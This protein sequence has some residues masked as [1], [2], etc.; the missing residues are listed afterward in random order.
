M[1]QQQQNNGEKCQQATF[2]K[3]QFK[4]TEDQQG[5]RELEQTLGQL[6]LA[7]IYG[8]FLQTKTEYITYIYPKYT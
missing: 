5:K 1:K 4:C 8:T 3:E 2:N 6:D 7:D